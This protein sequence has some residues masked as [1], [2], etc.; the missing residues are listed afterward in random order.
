MMI[1]ILTPVLCRGATP[2][3]NCEVQP[4]HNR[5]QIKE[6]F[7]NCEINNNLNAELPLTI[8]SFYKR[9]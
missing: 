1:N 2:R 5:I 3:Y 9:L 8:L 7:I 4:E 6:P